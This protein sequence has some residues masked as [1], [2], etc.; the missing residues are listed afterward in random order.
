MTAKEALERILEDVPEERLDE[1]VD[2]ARSLR[3]DDERE[4]WRQFGR[5][6]LAEAYRPDEPDYSMAEDG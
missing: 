6:Q 1:V 5:R 3:S 4:A 2:F